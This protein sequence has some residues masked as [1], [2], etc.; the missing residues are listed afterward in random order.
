MAEQWVENSY[1]KYQASRFVLFS[2]A[3]VKRKW[4]YDKNILKKR[5]K[6]QEVDQYQKILHKRKYSHQKICI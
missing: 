6:N 5:L 3:S 2:L 4:K 1:L